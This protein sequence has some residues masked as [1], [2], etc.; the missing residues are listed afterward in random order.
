MNA[1]GDFVMAVVLLP[2]LAILVAW[3]PPLYWRRYCTHQNKDKLLRATTVRNVSFV[4]FLLYPYCST[5]ILN[6]LRPCKEICEDLEGKV[7][8]SYLDTDY[9]ITCEDST[10]A[11]YRA[12]AQ[13]FTILY[14]VGLP[15]GL[16]AI[17]FRAHRRGMV[18]EKE[19]KRDKELRMKKK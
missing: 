19:R 14:V 8:T 16:A 13:V 3:L 11:A 2:A 12:A 6:L 5:N 7:C 1:Y 10:Y 18:R 15:L 9:S 4:L 17:L